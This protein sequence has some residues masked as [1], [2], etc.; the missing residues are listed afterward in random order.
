MPINSFQPQA[1]PNLSIGKVT[2]T[3]LLPFKLT[4]TFRP[5][6][7]SFSQLLRSK[8]DGDNQ[9]KTPQTR[10]VSVCIS[11]N[12]KNLKF[13]TGKCM[14]RQ[15]SGRISN[16]YHTCCFDTHFNP[17]LPSNFTANPLHIL[18]TAVVRKT[19]G[20]R[21]FLRNEHRFRSDRP[22]LRKWPI[23]FRCGIQKHFLPLLGHI[24]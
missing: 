20:H 21:K 18:Y 9:S 23:R 14:S 3:D 22:R 24:S 5:P 6:L 17:S 8:T 1:R 7:L 15:G 16:G 2:L 11:I 19:C 4:N 12:P 13:R 10:Y